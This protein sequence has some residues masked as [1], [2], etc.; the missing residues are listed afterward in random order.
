[1]DLSKKRPI[2]FS[3]HF[4]K[5]KFTSDI[6]DFDLLQKYENYKSCFDF[7]N[8]FEYDNYNLAFQSL[9]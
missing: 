6:L 2:N 3:F 7:K 8:F 1:I 5:K 4:Q 9:F